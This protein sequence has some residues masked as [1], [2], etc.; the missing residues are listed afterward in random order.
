MRYLRPVG[1]ATAVALSLTVAA[2]SSSSSSSSSSSPATSPPAATSAAASPVSGTTGVVNMSGSGTAT[3]TPLVFGYVNDDTGTAG[4]FPEETAGTEATIS[5]INDHMDGVNGHPIK[6]VPCSDDGTPA[7]AASCATQVLQSN[8]IGIIGGADFATSSS[9]PLFAA[10]GKPYIGG[11]AFSGPENT[12]S[13]SFQWNNTTAIGGAL[14]PYAIQTLHVKEI[15]GLYPTGNG[16]ALQAI[17]LSKEIA[18]NMGL[19]A[20]AFKTESFSATAPDLTP[21]IRAAAASNPGAIIGATGGPQCITLAQAMQELDVKAALLLPSGC[22]SKQNEAQAGS[23]FD[24][25]YAGGS[26]A[27]PDSPQWQSDPDMKLFN[28]ILQEYSPSTASTPLVSFALDGYQTVMNLRNILLTLP[29]SGITTAS[30]VNAL[31]N[32]VNEPDVL[33]TPYTCKTPPIKQVSGLCTVSGYVYEIQNG[34]DNLVSGVV[35]GA[36]YI[37]SVPGLT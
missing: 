5:Y 13:L 18:V 1:L 22:F 9:V 36:K 19:P 7:R 11:V 15:V 30:L 17:Q 31:R 8:P 26:A 20:S 27:Q 35:D 29:P 4:A 6:L 3:G 10:A 33:G 16:S 28:T 37:T 25:V 12:S 14:I 24:G 34:T 2:C 32:T 23:A 21:A